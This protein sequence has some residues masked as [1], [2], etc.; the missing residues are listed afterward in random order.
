MFYDETTKVLGVVLTQ[1]EIRALNHPFAPD[2]DSPE[3]R[4]ARD[5][6][7]ELFKI[8]THHIE[9]RGSCDMRCYPRLYDGAL[10]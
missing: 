6:S 1:E 9:K 2:D 3:A 10:L 8:R 4:R 7:R 5:M